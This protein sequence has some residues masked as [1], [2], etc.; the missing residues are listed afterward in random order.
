MKVK[1]K[2]LLNL[3]F[4]FFLFCINLIFKSIINNY[5]ILQQLLIIT[6]FIVIKMKFSTSVR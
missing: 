4:V 2:K 5:K 1:I 6:F 3:Y